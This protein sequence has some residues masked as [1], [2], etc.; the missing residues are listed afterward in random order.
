MEVRCRVV[1][2][3]H[4]ALS[5]NIAPY[6]LAQE[7]REPDPPILALNQ[8]LVSF[9]ETIALYLRGKEIVFIRT[10][11][12][13]LINN[14]L[15][16]K[17]TMASPMNQNGSGRMQLNIL[18]LQQNLKNV[19]EGVDL[20][21]AA[22]YFALFDKG[23]DGIVRKAVEDKGKVVGATHSQNPNVFTFEELKGLLELCY[24]ELMADSERGIASAAKKQM[25]DKISEM[26]VQFS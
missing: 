4:N 13:M 1:H 14:Y 12:G 22:N 18:V 26:S 8:E 5:P 11:L 15:I 2:S 16:G 7:V 9:D 23:P 25:Q 17:A 6:L 19:E 24:S 10:G 21:R 20:A 3:L